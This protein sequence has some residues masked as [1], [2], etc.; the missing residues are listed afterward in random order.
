MSLEH[1]VCG[2][3]VNHANQT[4]ASARATRIVNRKCPVCQNHTFLPLFLPLAFLLHGAARL[5]RQEAGDHGDPHPGA[6]GDGPDPFWGQISLRRGAGDA[7]DPVCMLLC[8]RLNTVYQ[9]IGPILVQKCHRKGS[10]RS[11]FA[12]YL[13]LVRLYSIRSEIAVGNFGRKFGKTS[14]GPPAG[15]SHQKPAEGMCSWKLNYTVPK[16]I[17]FH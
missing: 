4:P 3:S 17:P 8:G 9:P 5:R 6:R 11:H 13:A 10:F 12:K 15:F 1:S 7:R 14:W 16:K 2:G